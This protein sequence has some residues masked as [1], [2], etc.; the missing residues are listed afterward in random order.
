M[1]T[2]VPIE[3]PKR[4]ANESG[5]DSEGMAVQPGAVPRP[6]FDPEARYTARRGPRFELVKEEI[7]ILLAMSEAVERRSPPGASEDEKQALAEELLREDPELGR[8]S[9]RLEELVRANDESVVLALE[10]LERNEGDE[11]KDAGT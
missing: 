1:A 11:G 4:I 7:D 5:V 10:S 9:K 8:L 6:P 2:V 3:D